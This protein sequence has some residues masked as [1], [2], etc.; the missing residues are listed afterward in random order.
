M[1]AL[2]LPSNGQCLVQSLAIIEYLNELYPHPALYPQD[3]L[4]KAH[5][6]ELVYTIACDTHPIQNLRILKT[7]PEA[8]RPS[9]AKR[10]ISGGFETFEALL[11]RTCRHGRYCWGDSVTMADLVL[12]PQVYNAHRWGVD[13]SQFPLISGICENLSH[14]PAFKAAHADSQPDAQKA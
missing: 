13:M 8:D 11:N 10:I 6:L 9:H 2:K 3:P 14:L 7:Y 12:V 4:E 1:P 5:V